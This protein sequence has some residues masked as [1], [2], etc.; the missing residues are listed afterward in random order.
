MVTNPLVKQTTASHISGKKNAVVS[1]RF[2]YSGPIPPPALLN[3]YDSESR[4][5]IIAMAYK[6]SLHRQTIETSIISS[7]IVNEKTGMLIAALLTFLMLLSGVY[8]LMN[9]KDAVGFLLIFGPS[10]F[11]A[12]NYLYNKKQEDELKT[13]SPTETENESST[14]ELSKVRNRR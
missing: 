9:N 11:H 13:Q 7:N 10:L 6:Q 5:I 12:G 8:L 2:E 3:Q 4:K 1:R 14:Q